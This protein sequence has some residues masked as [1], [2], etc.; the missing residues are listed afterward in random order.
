MA[1]E[2]PNY[3]IDLG[4]KP[5]GKRNLK[6]FPKRVDA[7]YY[8]LTEKYGERNVLVVPCGK[9]PACIKAYRRMWSLRCEAEARLYKDNCFVTLTLDNDNVTKE[10]LKSHLQKFFKDLRN[11]GIKFRYFACGEYGRHP[12]T[13]DRERPHYHAILFNYIPGD[14]KPW[15]KSK[16]GSWQYTSEFI[17]KIWQKGIVTISPFEPACAGYV[18]GYVDKKETEEDGFLMMSTRP[19][20]GYDYYRK[21]ID[22]LVEFDNFI[23]KGGFAAKLPRYFETAA[24]HAF[25]DISSLKQKRIELAKTISMATAVEHGFSNIEEVYKYQGQKERRKKTYARNL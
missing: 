12:L 6:M 16:T 13:G 1:C 7:N 23:S 19:G 8:T 25:Y 5:N 17:S 22:E 20:L 4:I 3:F 14:L 24:D 2:S 18:A 21:H 10:V 15:C 11:H 9:C